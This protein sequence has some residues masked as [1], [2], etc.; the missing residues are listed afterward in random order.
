MGGEKFQGWVAVHGSHGARP[1]PWAALPVATHGGVGRVGTMSGPSAQ[2][3]GSASAERAE[4]VDVQNIHLRK[5]QGKGKPL[6]GDVGR[7]LTQSC[8]RETLYKMLEKK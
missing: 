5:Q 8:L 1:D 4:C 6:I 3:S 2:G 7:D